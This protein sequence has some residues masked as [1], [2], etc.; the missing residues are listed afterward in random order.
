MADT[1]NALKRVTTTTYVGAGAVCSAR[2]CAPLI[3]SDKRLSKQRRWATQSACMHASRG[4]CGRAGGAESNLIAALIYIV[5]ECE[6][7]KVLLL[8]VV[9]S[10]AC[11]ALFCR[12]SCASGR[13][14]R[15]LI[16]Q[17]L[18]NRTHQ[19]FSM[20]FVCISIKGARPEISFALFAARFSKRGE[21]TLKFQPAGAFIRVVFML[22]RCALAN[23]PWPFLVAFFKAGP[24]FGS[25]GGQEMAKFGGSLVYRSIKHRRIFMHWPLTNKQWAKISLSH[26]SIL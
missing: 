16:P 17:T 25:N 18:R 2:R 20:A 11:P 4:G 23:D 1:S 24:L 26:C 19:S 9:P 3:I 5:H 12:R 8:R 22:I 21:A 10:A 14:R 6:G 7:Q 13:A 15:I